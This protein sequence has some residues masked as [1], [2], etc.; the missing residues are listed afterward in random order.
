M[1]VDP[2]PTDGHCI[3]IGNEISHDPWGNWKYSEKKTNYKKT[4]TI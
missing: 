2:N 1:L 3:K 4:T